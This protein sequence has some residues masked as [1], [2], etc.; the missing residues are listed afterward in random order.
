MK[1]AKLTTT[2]LNRII[3]EEVAKFGAEEDTE[4]RAKDTEEVDA[5]DLADSLEKNIDFMHALKIEEARLIARLAKIKEQR[6]NTLKKI[7]KK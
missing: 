6:Q 7:A 2:L 5:D 3:K 4:K 1:T